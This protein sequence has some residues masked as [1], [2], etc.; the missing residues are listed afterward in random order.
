MAQ[1]VQLQTELGDL[2]EERDVNVLVIFREESD[3]QDGLEKV[4]AQTETPFTLALDTDAVNTKIYSPGH[5]VHDSYLID[6]GGVVRA[7]LKG[8]RYDRAQ[9]EEFANALRE[10]D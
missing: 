7:I 4:F 6:G 1:L 5:R 2:F 9:A 3:G 10:L 8:T